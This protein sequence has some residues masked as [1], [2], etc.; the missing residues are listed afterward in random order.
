ML[1]QRCYYALKPFIPWRVRI[2]LRRLYV[3][4][5]RRHSTAQWPILERAGRTPPGW[6]GW[7]DG[8]KFALVLTHDVEG[9]AGLRQC[10]ELAA[11]EMEA[12]FR[13]SFNFVPEGTYRAP[14]E[15]RSWLGAQG[16]E[17]GVHDLNHD[18]W[19]FGS[20]GRFRSKARRIN[21]YLREWKAHG[22]RSGF[23]LRNLDWIHQLEIDYDTSTF[24]TDPFE[25]QPDGAGTIFPFWIAPPGDGLNGHSHPRNGYVELPYTLPQD[26]TLFLVLQETSPRIWIEKLD[27]IAERGGMALV[28]VHPDYLDFSHDSHSSRH[29]PVSW[30]AQFLRHVSERYSAEFWNPLAHELASWHR[31]EHGLVEHRSSETPRSVHV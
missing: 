9:P 27:W 10:R 22:F 2:A 16:F 20:P 6:R 31:R 29:Y 15:L 12:G 21:H 23:M 11:L 19:L 3:R 8:K 13:S 24:D 25:F 30:Y 5:L 1:A 17:V 14:P 4:R 7:P 18:G 28:N 26:S